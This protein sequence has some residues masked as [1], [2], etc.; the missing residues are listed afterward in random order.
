MSEHIGES[1]EMVPGN[2]GA[3]ELGCTCPEGQERLLVGIRCSQ[4]GT[5]ED[6]CECE[7]TH[8]WWIKSDC[9]L[10]SWAAR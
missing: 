4:P 9:P 1:N 7:A 10:H 5:I 3:I 6:S 2:P 8:G